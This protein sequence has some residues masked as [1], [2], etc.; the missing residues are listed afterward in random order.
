[1]EVAELVTKFSFTGS[2]SPLDKLNAGLSAGIAKVK[3]I[4]SKLGETS[5]KISESFSRVS[6][7]VV[8][9]YGALSTATVALNG[10]LAHT[11]STADAQVQLSRETNI[12]MEAI[13]EWGYVASVNGS[14]AEALES[15][16]NELSKRMGEAVIENN[17]VTKAFDRLGISLRDNNGDMKTADVVMRELADSFKR[18]NLSSQEQ[19]AYLD[20]LG[21]DESMLQTLQLS[22]DAID[23]LIKKAK[24]LG[25]L[26]QDDA[27]QIASF[28][29]SLTTLK[30]GL[31]NVQKRLAISFAPQLQN[32]AENFTNVLIA[33]REL[34]DGG[35]KKFFELM[36]NGLGAIF[37]FGGLLYSLIDNTIGLKG[38]LLLAGGAMI[39]LN[40]AMWFSPI[41]AIIAG[42]TSLILVYDDLMTA[43]KGGKSVIKEWFKEW[44]NIDIV[45]TIK[46]INDSFME[47]MDSIDISFSGMVAGVNDGLSRFKQYFKNMIAK[48]LDFF[49]PVIDIMKSIANFEL[50]NFLGDGGKI[51]YM[52]NQATIPINPQKIA[53]P[54]QSGV[55]NNSSKT[56]N[57]IHIEIKTDNPQMAGQAVTDELQTMFDNANFQFSG[58]GR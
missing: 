13:Q 47:A 19:K 15:S 46:D 55:V 34:I 11:L 8:T 37:R 1:M 33:N 24:A 50:P 42:V 56:D 16:I 2:L 45:E 9:H 25:V 18:L 38:V 6:K 14:S 30:F 36:N 5:S 20:K 58:G 39:Y 44:F 12:S 23:G 54:N 17:E 4:S 27:N 51:E 48:V 21:I 22:T 57:N 3:K 10:Y 40:R 26:S 28:N 53:I 29:D 52:D 32:L 31:D 35:L 43:M 7:S 41:G 49:Q